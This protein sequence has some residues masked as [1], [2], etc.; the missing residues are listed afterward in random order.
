MQSSTMV[1]YSERLKWAMGDRVS[2]QQLADHLRITYQAVKKVV[3]GKTKAFSVE[4]H[5][6]AAEYLAVDARWLGTGVGSPKPS[7]A[8][9]ANAGDRFTVEDVG[10][11]Y[12]DSATKEAI[13][14]LQSLTPERRSAALEMLRLFAGHPQ[15]KSAEDG[16]DLPVA[17]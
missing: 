13:T 11:V 4:H 12:Q 10:G 1:D 14:I 2:V 16:P 7:P 8:L 6:R 5:H 15:R 3:D 9:Q 17:A